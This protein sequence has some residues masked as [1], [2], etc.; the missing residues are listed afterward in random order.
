MSNTNALIIFTR[1]PELGKGKRRLA[2]TVGDEAAF[3]IYKFLLSH[4]REI[5]KSVNAQPQVWYSEKLHQNDDWDN[6]IYQKHVQ[7]GED[8]GVRMQHAFNTAFKTHDKV[9]IIGSDMYDLTTQDLDKAFE[10]L[11]SHDAV[12]GPAIDGGYYLL[13][14]NKQV[15]ANVFSNKEWGTE[16]VQAQTL[17]D[18]KNLNYTLLEPRNDVDFYEDIKDVPAFQH[19]LKHINA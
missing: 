14:F 12:M 19:F 3:E 2:A 13:G 9:V 16:T 4:T 17:K 15:P 6:E 8:L 11:D 18:L 1:N 10:L 7:Q 5:T